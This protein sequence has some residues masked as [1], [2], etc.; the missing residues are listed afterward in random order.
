[1]WKRNT[2]LVSVALILLLVS[3]GFL[4]ACGE[5]YTPE[6]RI[7]DLPGKIS[8]KKESFTTLAVTIIIP[9]SKKGEYSVAFTY[10]NGIELDIVNH[11]LQYEFPVTKTETFHLIVTAKET[12]SAKI[13]VSVG[14]PINIRKTCDVTV[15][16]S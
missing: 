16:D 14:P 2:V 1:M 7:T 6:V 15:S 13:T 3:A 5:V 10:E 4:G 8:L 11:N 12:G 9:S